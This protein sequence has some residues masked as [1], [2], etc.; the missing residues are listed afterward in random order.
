[1]TLPTFGNITGLP[2]GSKAYFLAQLWDE[3]DASL[4][5]VTTED[6]EAEGLSAD[7]EAWAALKAVAHRPP[8]IYFPE[9]DE[10]ARIAA[11]GR[12]AAEKRALLLCSKGALEKPIFS[13]EQL[14]AQTF[15]LRPGSAYPRSK[16]LERLAQGGY[17]RT[18]MV[19]MEGELA[20]RG[21]VVDL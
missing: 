10:A 6:L 4:V 17:S 8:V 2:G 12:W 15:E 14:K 21:E 7:L 1:M 19:E 9:L 11:L 13:P 20:V 18:D 16:L 3:I 5:L